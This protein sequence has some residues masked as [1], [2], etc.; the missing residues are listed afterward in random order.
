M[1]FA[2][3]L[4]L[5]SPAAGIFQQIC[6]LKHNLEDEGFLLRFMVSRAQGL[7]FRILEALSRSFGFRAAQCPNQQK[8]ALGIDGLLGVPFDLVSRV[9]KVGYGGL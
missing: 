7:G 3:P 8:K 5:R 6:D 2:E 1:A 4:Y 9:S